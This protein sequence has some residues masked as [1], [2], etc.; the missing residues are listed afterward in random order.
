[1]RAAYGESLRV[2]C[3]HENHFQGRP[4]KQSYAHTILTVVNMILH[5]PCK[6]RLSCQSKGRV[7]HCTVHVSS[8]T[9]GLESR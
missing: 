7:Q 1:M 9:F 3:V 8:N 6:G 4:L 2:H 5:T